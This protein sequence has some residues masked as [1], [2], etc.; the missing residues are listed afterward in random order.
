MMLHV[1]MLKKS[2]VR[3]INNCCPLQYCKLS[4]FFHQK[5]NKN[6]RKYFDKTVCTSSQ[7]PRWWH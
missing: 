3:M 5:N 2:H 4:F 6:E 1:E 7:L